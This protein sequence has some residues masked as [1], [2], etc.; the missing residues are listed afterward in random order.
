MTEADLGRFFPEQTF[1]SNSFIG[2]LRNSSRKRTPHN[3]NGSPRFCKRVLNLVCSYADPRNS[4]TIPTGEAF[5]QLDSFKSLQVPKAPDN[6][7]RFTTQINF[8][9]C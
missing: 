3:H 8:F 7:S 4:T 1:N 5:N 6:M 2:R 9:N